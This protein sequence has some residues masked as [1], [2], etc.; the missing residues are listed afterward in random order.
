M[1]NFIAGMLLFIS[2][3]VDAQVS[4]VNVPT[5]WVPNQVILKSQ[6][7]RYTLFYQHDG[8]LVIYKNGTQP[9]WATGTDGKAPKSLNFQ[10]DGNI[11]LYG[12]NPA[13]AWAA[14]CHNKAGKYLILQNDGNLVI[15][16]ARNRAIWATNTWEKH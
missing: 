5:V 7:G 8:N 4:R 16:T 10:S 3:S 14:N 12:Y 6:D 13:V 15:Y 2:M 11:V 9:I 1:K